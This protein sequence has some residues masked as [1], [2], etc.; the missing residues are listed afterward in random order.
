MAISAVTGKEIIPRKPRINV[1][2]LAGTYT[3][4][5]ILMA[6]LLMPALWMAFSS[7]KPNDRLFGT[8]PDFSLSALTFDNYEWAMRPEGM[9]ML[10]LLINTFATN[11]MSA[12]LTTVFCAVAGYGLA[13]YKGGLS[14]AIVAFLVLAQMIQGPMIMVPWYNIASTLDL[15]NTREVL[16]LIYQTLTIPAAIWLMAGFYR[17]IPIELEEAAAIDG[18]SKIKTFFTII[19]P[20]SLPGM[21]AISLYA[22]ILGWN[23]YQY[24]LILTSSEYSKTLQIGIA[25]VM[26][27]IG[28]TNW[29]GILAAGTIAVIPAVILFSFVQKTLISGLTAGSVKG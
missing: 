23:D 24:A 18:C 14:R 9:N 13:R 10:Q 19:L 29:G 27:S 2:E 25:Q 21:A 16:V 3:A 7:F 6:F 11:L 15:I 22:F 8:T 17:A 4:L 5:F 20:L 1:G 28:A 12:V 26:N